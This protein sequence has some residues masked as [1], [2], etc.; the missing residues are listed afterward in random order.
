MRLLVAVVLIAVIS[1]AA[2]QLLPWWI[3]AVVSFAVCFV[4]RLSGGKGFLAGFLGIL[5][6]W[7]AVAFV[8]DTANEQILSSRMAELFKL[9]GSLLFLLVG[10]LV[11]GIVGGLA[12]WSGALLRKSLDKR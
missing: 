6:L 8:R 10:A 7:F 11:G 12:G 3:I 4:L 2:E 9:P 1:F 5:I